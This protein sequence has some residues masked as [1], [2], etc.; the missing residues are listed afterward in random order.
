MDT[1]GIDNVVSE[2]DRLAA[3]V[4]AERFAIPQLLRDMAAQGKTFYG[5][6]PVIPARAD[7]VA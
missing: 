5:A 6:N 4:D 3:S 7:E 2:C 1:L